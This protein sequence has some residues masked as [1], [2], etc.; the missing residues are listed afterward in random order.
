MKFIKKHWFFIAILFVSVFRF[1]MTFRL[2]S[3]YLSNL[4]YDD[5][6]MMDQMISLSQGNY[7]GS[8]H[9]R[10]LIKGIFFPCVLFLARFFSVSYSTFFTILYICASLYF[11][12]SCTVFTKSKK[13]LYVIYV[14]LLFNPVSY[15]SELFQRLYRTTLALPQLL[16]FL[17]TIFHLLRQDKKSIIHFVFLGIVVSSMALTR[18]DS[19]WVIVTCLFTIFCKLY[20]TKQMKTLF[21]FCIPLLIVIAS[22][23]IVSFINLHHYQYYTYN[24]MRNSSYKDFYLKVL[25]IKDD[26]QIDYVDI[27]KST[28]YKLADYLPSLSFTR[29]R[30]DYY[31]EHLA[32]DQGQI[33]NGRMIW[34]LRN[35]IFYEKK[36]P[37]SLEA[38]DFYNKLCKEMDD[39]FEK[40][41]FE[42]EFVIPSLFFSTPS[43]E[44]LLKLPQTLIQMVGYTSSYQNVKTY[45][46]NDLLMTSD[47]SFY[48][49]ENEAYSVYYKDYQK[50]ENMISNNMIS[51]EIVRILYKWGTILFSIVALFI[52]LKNIKVFDS[53]NI[54]LHILVVSYLIIMG[55]VAYT[56]VTSFPSIRYRYLG[57]IYILQN[58]FIIVNMIRL[59][60]SKKKPSKAH[61]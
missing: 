48:S 49:E 59:F 13:I 47:K 22:L 57:C 50:S 34:Y 36:F 44:D 28:L 10:T 35:W 37:S 9:D 30:I 39:L 38:Q 56:H 54:V 14:V 15:S 43:W 8:Y 51:M 40:G 11:L 29:D 12:H 18:E 26:E 55:G 60:S 4:N 58:M 16:F 21:Y 45:T 20:Q 3:F 1:L 46:A 7:L 5:Q 52:Y 17:G 42:K 23:N 61:D 2:P 33:D 41:I 6:L 27:P 32:N 53:M 25:E 31:Y 24:E 19:I